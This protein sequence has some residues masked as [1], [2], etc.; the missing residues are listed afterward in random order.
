MLHTAGYRK[1]RL[2]PPDHHMDPPEPDPRF[3]VV[4]EGCGDDV[5]IDE[6]V[7]LADHPD[8]HWVCRYIPCLINA[9]EELY[10]EAWT[11]KK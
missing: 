2:D 4:C 11:V 3:H 1:N 9:G 8:Q 7:N 5:H 10:Y 6:A